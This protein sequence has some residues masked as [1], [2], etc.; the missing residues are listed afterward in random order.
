MAAHDKIARRY[1]IAISDFLGEA[2]KSKKVVEELNAFAGVINQNAEL[3]K[4]VSSEVFSTQDKSHVAE[5]IAKKMGL[6]EEGQK[7]I[8]L[9]AEQGRLRVV[10][11]IA[12]HLHRLVLAG[13]GVVPLRVR[14]ATELPK[15]HQTKVEEKFSKLLGQKVEASYEV[16]PGL[17][18]GL[19]VEAAGRTYEGTVVGWLTDLEER[20]AGGTI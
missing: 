9:L 12:S 14:T 10:G 5:D 18:G 20:I 7:V 11:Q 15:S 2:G 17:I 1:A 16:E 13:S 3:K 4:V 19:Q 6:T 8:R